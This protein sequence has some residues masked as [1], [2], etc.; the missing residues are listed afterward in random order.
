MPLHIFLLYNQTKN[1]QICYESNTI[2]IKGKKKSRLRRWL[3]YF[4]C[5]R[6]DD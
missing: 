6:L 3:R 4:K 1:N 5:F 2:P